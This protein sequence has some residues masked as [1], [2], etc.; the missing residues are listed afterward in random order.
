M[1]AVS[2]VG[3]GQEDKKKSAGEQC[4]NSS[5]CADN[6]CHRGICVSPNPR[7]NGSPCSGIA[8]CKSLNCQSSICVPGKSAKGV[9][10]LNKEE[11]ESSTCSGGF[12]TSISVQVDGGVPDAKAPDL[13]VA[14]LALLDAPIPDAPIPDQLIP[15]APIPDQLIPDA[16][17]PDQLIPDALIPDAPL[18]DL[19]IPDLP[20]PD[21]PVPDL[22]IPDLPMPDQLVP[23]LPIPD[24]PLPDQT[25]PDSTVDASA[26]D[27]GLPTVKDPNGFAINA[28]QTIKYKKQPEVT[29]NSGAGQYAVAWWHAQISGGYIAVARADTSGKVLDTTPVQV[30]ASGSNKEPS[31]ASDGTNYLVVWQNGYAVF[32][33][34]LDKNLKTIGSPAGFLISANKASWL[35][36]VR[37][38]GTN[39]VVFWI[40]TGTPRGIMGRRIDKSGT[41]LDSGPQGVYTPSGNNYY[42]LDAAY[43]GAHFVVTWQQNNKSLGD[44]L[45]ARVVT[46]GGFKVLQNPATT[47]LAV[48]GDNERMPGVSCVG[49]SCLVAW[50]QTSTGK[51]MIVA[52]LV[53]ANGTSGSAIYIGN[54]YNYARTPVVSSD[55]HRYMV[56]WTYGTSS[57]AWVRD[58]YGARLSKSGTVL[59]G[60]GFIISSA[61]NGQV[62]P[63]IIRGPGQ[64]LTVWEDTRNDYYVKDLYAARI[65]P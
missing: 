53:H 22:P 33:K 1:A 13:G 5:D 32:G 3:C 59:D 16:L 15:D 27:A 20:V 26:W 44:I 54:S 37:F 55:G 30:S 19:T 8:Q 12:C 25:M 4:T 57:S 18:P 48:S 31:I 46:K 41:F 35:P 50:Y 43:N 65:T 7:D 60:P 45:A 38:D 42:G 62:E 6:I 40:S 39:Y 14:D 21:L 63:T 51:D 47:N 28:N 11:C 52:R 2:L 29:Y 17:I 24:L 49:P 61:K 23:D 10:C 56:V 58:I 9:K 64:Y 34:R 36:M